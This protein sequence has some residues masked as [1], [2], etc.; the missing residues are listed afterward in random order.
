MTRGRTGSTVIMD[1]LNMI[2]NVRGAVIEPFLKADFSVLVN[3]QP[4]LIEQMKI[5][6]PFEI[7]KTQGSW[8]KLNRYFLNTEGLINLYLKSAEDSGIREGVRLFGFKVLSNHFEE[9]PLLKETLIN[10]GYRVVY[11][12]RNIPR[13]VI[14]GVI[15][16]Q[17]G[18]YNTKSDY[19]D[20]NRYH[21]NTEEFQNLVKW[22]MQAVLN[23]IAFL[24]M[25]G[26]KFIEVSYEEFV[27]NR[28]EF[29]DKVLGFLGISSELPKASTYSVM[30]KDP[31]YTIV[32]YREIVDCADTMGVPIE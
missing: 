25:V 18:T 6:I 5:M 16:N 2:K 1:E 7:W 28:Q 27:A 15:A 4:E 11:L 13:Q 30:I 23:D 32:N 29:F 20:D 17:R 8:W 26:F 9:T 3:R 14:S 24:K 31:M 21:I 19:H 22:G 10:R 12:K